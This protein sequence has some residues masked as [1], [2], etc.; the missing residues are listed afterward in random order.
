MGDP[1]FTDDALDC[2]RPYTRDDWEQLTSD[3]RVLARVEEAV[4]GQVRPYGRKYEVRGTI[5]G[6]RRSA[7]IVT[8]WILQ[9]GE[10]APRFVT[11]YPGPRS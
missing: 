8:V 9:E 5:R 6:P 1:R 3:F 2:N 4:A 11:A 7:E 10:E